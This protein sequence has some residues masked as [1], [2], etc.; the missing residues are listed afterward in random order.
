MIESVPI[1]AVPAS[2]IAHEANPGPV[3]LPLALH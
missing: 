2:D 1:E 3:A